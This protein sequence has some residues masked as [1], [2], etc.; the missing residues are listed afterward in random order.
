MNSPQETPDQ[1]LA[2][3]V[4]RLL[5]IVITA[6]ML[7]VCLAGCEPSESLITIGDTPKPTVIY[8]PDSPE[9]TFTTTQIDPEACIA[10]AIEPRYEDTE[11]AD[12]NEWVIDTD[13]YIVIEA[14]IKRRIGELK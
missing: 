9:S 13:D 10:H 6:V 7:A 8:I 3:I 11:S 1:V 2:T 14:E 5:F 4:T 12:P